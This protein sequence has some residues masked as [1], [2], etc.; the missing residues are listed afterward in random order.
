MIDPRVGLIVGVLKKRGF[1]IFGVG[2]GEKGEIAKKGRKLAEHSMGE[3]CGH[4]ACEDSRNNLIK[5]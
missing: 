2:S 3:E 1:E 4:D 5:I